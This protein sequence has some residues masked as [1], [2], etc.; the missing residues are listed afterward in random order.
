MGDDRGGDIGPASPRT[1][2]RPHRRDLL[3]LADRREVQRTRGA[4]AVMGLH[5][6]GGH[7]PVTV[8]RIRKQFV[9][10]IGGSVFDPEMMMRVD[11]GEVRNENLFTSLRQPRKIG[12]RVAVASGD[13]QSHQASR[14]QPRACVT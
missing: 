1:R 13:I 4:V 6:D 12:R 7:D 11:D 8:F 5:E 10:K 9:E 14:L 2:D 3:G